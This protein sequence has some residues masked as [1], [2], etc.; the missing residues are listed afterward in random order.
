MCDNI[1]LKTVRRTQPL[2]KH[3][4]GTHIQ[5]GRIEMGPSPFTIGFENV[6]V[7]K[8]STHSPPL[9]GRICHTVAL[10]LCASG[11][12]H[13]HDEVVTNILLLQADCYIPYLAVHKH[14][15]RCCDAGHISAFIDPTTAEASAPAMEY[16]AGEAPIGKSSI[17]VMFLSVSKSIENRQTAELSPT[18]DWKYPIPSGRLLSTIFTGQNPLFIE[19]VTG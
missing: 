16:D 11:W 17:D 15:N 10:R 19:E 13:H 12:V 14:F 9:G 7:R 1:Q 5:P 2:N 4:K 3:L 6:T 18:D 8:C